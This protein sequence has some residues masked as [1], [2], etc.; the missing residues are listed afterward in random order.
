MLDRDFIGKEE[1]EVMA[2]EL[3]KVPMILEMLGASVYVLP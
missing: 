1:V 2:F 3:F